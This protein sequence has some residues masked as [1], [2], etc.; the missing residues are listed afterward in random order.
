M[1]TVTRF[2]GPF[3]PHQH[4]GTASRR[5]SY[6]FVVRPLSR[7]PFRQSGKA[8]GEA[9]QSIYFLLFPIQL[10]LI[11]GTPQPALLMFIP[12]VTR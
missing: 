2:P 5:L 4:H 12:G 9:A 11:F 3:T 8:D 1:L 6:P 7:H 10:N